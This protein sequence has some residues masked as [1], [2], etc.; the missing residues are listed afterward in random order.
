MPHRSQ[1]HNRNY[2]D[3]R[4][5]RGNTNNGVTSHSQP[6]VCFIVSFS[7]QSDMDDQRTAWPLQCQNLPVMPGLLEIFSYLPCPPSPHRLNL[8]IVQRIKFNMAYLFFTP[9]LFLPLALAL[10]TPPT[11]LTHNNTTPLLHSR[12]ISSGLV[13]STYTSPNCGGAIFGED[14]AATYGSNT[15][16]QIKSYRLSREL[17]AREQLDFS[18]PPAGNP[19]DCGDVPCPCG[20]FYQS[21]PKDGGVGCRTLGSDTVGCF[22]LWLTDGPDE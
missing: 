8:Q 6:F 14:Y 10:P 16:A 1:C 13:L 19:N 18:T 2:C 5:R 21:A 12:Q 20:L 7:F 17:L 15:E 22:R 4:W 3:K 9:L 11:A